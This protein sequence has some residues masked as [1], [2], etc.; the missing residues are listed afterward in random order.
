MK[1]LSGVAWRVVAA[2]CLCGLIGFVLS[3]VV[4]R[5]AARDAI[6][7]FHEPPA[8][9]LYRVYERAR[10]EADP[11]VWSLHE[12]SG[13]SVFAYDA[14]THRSR[15]P[16]APPLDEAAVARLGPGGGGGA[17][18]NGGET[19]AVNAHG[20]TLV[21]G[22][23]LVFRAGADGPCAILQGTWPAQSVRAELLGLFPLGALLAAMTAATVGFFAL[24]RPIQRVESR[25]AALARHLADVAHDLR[26]PISSLHLALEQA[27]GTSRE[28][29]LRP[30]LSAAMNDAVY[31]AA[32]TTNLR[33]ASEIQDGWD[34][35][36]P[37]AEV[38][39]TD[40]AS[41]VVG[42]ARFFARQRG[43]TLE[44]SVPDDPTRAR[45]EPVAAEQALSNVVQNA[46]LHGE[47]GGHVAVIL[48]T[49]GGAF[50]LT[51][52]DDGPGVPPSELPRLGERTFRSDA[53]RQRDASGSGLG[54][55]I[56]HEVCARCGWT[57][58]FSREVPHGLRVTIRGD[59]G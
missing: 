56:T 10:C 4:L 14:Q 37:G 39:L 24:V 1:P 15:N 5:F 51:V 6:A 23:A 9:Y 49:S 2:T 52:V 53:A 32:L 34:P 20:L 43:L 58:A 35:A 19:T 40:V 47:S 57:L 54:L 38:D 50:T 27:L 25:R 3:P 22:G 16:A 36:P 13:V 12:A 18:G 46:I 33:L 55:A 8:E 21:S 11:D 42:R 28:P 7:R 29:E 59:M 31:L 41:R 30:L 44:V 48:D 17:G 45:C 26:T